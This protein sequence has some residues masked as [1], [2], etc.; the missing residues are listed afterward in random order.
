MMSLTFL[1]LLRGAPAFLPCERSWRK[2]R[3][4]LFMRNQSSCWWYDFRM[5][6]KRYRASTKEKNKT[7][8]E[9]KAAKVFLELTEGKTPAFAKKCPLLTELAESF[10]SLLEKTTKLEPDSKRYY[11]NGWRLLK[12]T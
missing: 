7:A 1:I 4:E 5:R 8:A 2:K 3:V 6:G 12:E 11:R 9:E 10:E